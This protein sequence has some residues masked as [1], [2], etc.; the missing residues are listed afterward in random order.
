MLMSDFKVVVN[1][2]DITNLIKSNL[3]SLSYDDKEGK[4]SDEISISLNGLYDAPKFGDKIE[5]YLGYI[6]NL[7]KCGSFNLQTVCRDF[8]ANT[9]EIRATSVDFADEN[10]KVKRTRTFENTSIFGIAKKIA[11]EENLGLKTNGDDLFINS[12]LQ[13]NISNIEFLYNLAFLFGYLM[14]VKNKTIIIGKKTD[15][16]DAMSANTN[17]NKFILSLDELYELE[18]MQAYRNTYKSVEIEWQDIATGDI[19]SLKA[20]NGEPSY[21]MRI[22]QPKNESEAYSRA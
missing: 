15:L 10:M 14:A 9:T 2:A 4:D 12:K 6:N 22:A 5:L 1:D 20:R 11:N 21:K 13:D 8:K 16:T 3:I 18:I 17:L 7:Y 19:K